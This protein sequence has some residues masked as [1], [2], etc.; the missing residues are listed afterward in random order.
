[1]VGADLAPHN[2]SNKENNLNF[3]FSQRWGMAFWNLA[4]LRDRGFADPAQ[5]A[6]VNRGAYLATALGHCG[7]CHTPRN[8][9]A[10][11]AIEEVP[12]ARGAPTTPSRCA[13][14][15]VAGLGFVLIPT[16]LVGEEI[17][18]VRLRH[19]LPLWS[20]MINTKPSGIFGIF[21]PNRMVPPKRC[22]C[23]IIH[24]NVVRELRDA[25]AVVGRL[26]QGIYVNPTL[27]DDL[28]RMKWDYSLTVVGTISGTIPRPA[29]D[30]SCVRTVFSATG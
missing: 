14:A 23:S 5:S 30:V 2:V 22:G 8:C 21:P 11:N 15:A 28:R 20:S 1:M 4:F 18:A 29:A 24:N 12:T 27:A 6:A 9:R 10:E 26:P 16:W 25:D 19:A 7:E 17:K 13:D 3:P